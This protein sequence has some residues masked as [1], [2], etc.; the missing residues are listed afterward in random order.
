MPEI[1]LISKTNGVYKR[2]YSFRINITE[3]IF[4]IRSCIDVL[5]NDMKI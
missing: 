5:A 1:K 2:N 4:A 3:G